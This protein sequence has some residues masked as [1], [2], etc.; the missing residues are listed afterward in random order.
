MWKNEKSKTLESRLKPG[1]VT[2]CVSKR[3]ENISRAGSMIDSKYPMMTAVACDS[4][5]H[6]TPHTDDGISETRVV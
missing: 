4:S 1:K 5:A 6:S 3:K 2:A